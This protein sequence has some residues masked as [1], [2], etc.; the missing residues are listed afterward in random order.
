[1]GSTST[2]RS[3]TLATTTEHQGRGSLYRFKK[4]LSVVSNNQM[5]KIL[6][7][8]IFSHSEFSGHK[9]FWNKHKNIQWTLSHLIN[10]RHLRKKTGC[11][12]QTHDDGFKLYCDD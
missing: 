8:R 9:D 2:T 11:E 10:I 7:S 5:E 3:T 1:L 6:N 12:V 4:Y